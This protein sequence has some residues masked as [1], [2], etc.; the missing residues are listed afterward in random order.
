MKLI[1]NIFASLYLVW[2]LVVFIAFMLLMFPFI[3]FI[4]L[5][6]KGKKAQ[7]LSF[8]CLRIWAKGT[9]VLCLYRIKIKNREAIDTSQ[10]YIYVCNHGS[11]LDAISVVLAAPQAFKPLGKIEM[12]KAPIFGIIYKK[13]V[14]MLDRKSP[15]SR[16]ASVQ[17]LKVEIA[18]GQSIFIFPEGT[19]NTTE[20]LLGNFYDGAF[21]IAIETQT[22][23][24]PMVLINARDLLPRKAPLDVK[25]GTIT[26]VFLPPVP[27]KGLGTSDVETLKATV[28]AQMAQAIL[29]NQ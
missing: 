19:M 14:V 9:A 13:L 21:R 16:A 10:S 25:P 17:A 11:Y 20:E 12:V 1:R 27:V 22:P 26:C 15:E 2:G 29:A 28:K 5:L 23:I 7:A 6:F 4:Q 3:I 8:T 18:A 24:V